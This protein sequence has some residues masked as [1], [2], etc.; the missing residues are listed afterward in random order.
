MKCDSWFLAE[1]QQ[2]VVFRGCAR[3]EEAAALPTPPLI[4]WADCGADRKAGRRPRSPSIRASLKM[5]GWECSGNQRGLPGTSA[6]F[7]SL[8]PENHWDFISFWHFCAEKALT[9]SKKGA[10]RSGVSW[11][12]VGKSRIFIF[13]GILEQTEILGF[14]GA[15]F[16]S[17]C[18]AFVKVF[19]RLHSSH[20]TPLIPYPSRASASTESE[21]ASGAKGRVCS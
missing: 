15:T 17:A 18:S 19:S 3:S 13:M 9:G 5:V 10:K 2:C 21:G 1:L 4:T 6:W 7:C 14:R 20:D 11:Y 8:V 16:A 12:R